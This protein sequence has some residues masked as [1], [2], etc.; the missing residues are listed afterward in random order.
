MRVSDD[1][2][3]VSDATILKL[4]GP[5]PKVRDFFGGA[6]HTSFSSVFFNGVKFIGKE[7]SKKAVSQY[8]KL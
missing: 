7:I 1:V 5:T 4:R 2:R 8:Y 3:D 6:M